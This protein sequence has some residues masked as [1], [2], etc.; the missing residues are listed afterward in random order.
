MFFD[1]FSDFE[2]YLDRL[3]LFSMRLGLSRMREALA[4]MGLA[5]PEAAVVQVVGTNGKG[6]TSGFLDALARAHGLGAGLYLSPH[7]VGVRER[8]RINGRL[9][10][11]A[12]WLSAANAVMGACS[13][14]GLTYFEVLTVMA[15]CLF[16]EAGVDLIILEAGLGGT[17][18][19]TCAASADLVVMTPVGLDHEAVLGPTLVDIARDKSGALGRCPAVM[20]VHEPEVVR[21]FQGATGVQPLV[22]LADCAVDGGFAIP[23]AQS[24][25]SLTA[26]LLP[27]HPPYQVANASLALLAWSRLA[28]ARGWPFEAR[29]CTEALAQARFAGRFCRHGRVLVDGAHNPMGLTALCSALEARG[30]SFDLLVFQAMRDKTLEPAV[31]GRLRALALQIVV[32]ALSGN[33]RAWNPMDLAARFGPDAMVAPDIGAALDLAHGDVLICGSLYLVGAY[34]ALY[35]EHLVL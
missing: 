27:G 9:V 4:R 31:L 24:P 16:R 23:T 20:G 25:L 18:D 28:P 19:A 7:L 8:I 3:G 13:D 11:E 12:Q 21:V 15:L 5:R 34:Y 32:P 26:D 14:I 1:A 29:L 22:S 2:A 35:P 6:S 10:S 17:H 30:E 33:E